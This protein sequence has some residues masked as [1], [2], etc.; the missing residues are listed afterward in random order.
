MIEVLEIRLVGM[1]RVMEFANLVRLV[2]VPISVYKLKFVCPLSNI[3]NIETTNKYLE[4]A[5]FPDDLESVT[6]IMTS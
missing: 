2:R 4:A 3:W 5:F 1:L 6:R